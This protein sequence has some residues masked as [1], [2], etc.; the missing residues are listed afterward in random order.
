MH[1][2]WWVTNFF[3]VSDAEKMMNGNDLRQKFCHALFQHL[4]LLFL[5]IKNL[6]LHLNVWK[7]NMRFA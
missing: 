3:V 1:C 6:I 4:M 5:D 2:A 7:Q